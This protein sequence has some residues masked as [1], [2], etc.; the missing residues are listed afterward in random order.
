MIIS[1]AARWTHARQLDV[2]HSRNFDSG[3]AVDR[4]GARVLGKLQYL[5]FSV[6]HN[7]TQNNRA[8]VQSNKLLVLRITWKQT[9][10]TR[11]NNNKKCLVDFSAVNDSNSSF[12]T[13]PF[14]FCSLRTNLKLHFDGA[15]FGER[16]TGKSEGKCGEHVVKMPS[17]RNSSNWWGKCCTSAFLYVCWPSPWRK[18]VRKGSAGGDR[19]IGVHMKTEK[20][21]IRTHKARQTRNFDLMFEC[22]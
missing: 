3:I 20:Q 10:T 15:A 11:L 7:T 17:T 19:Q 18:Y 9:R 6:S 4:W 16:W 1:S 21:I 2:K 5:L 12:R 13:W 8:L 14:L 22:N